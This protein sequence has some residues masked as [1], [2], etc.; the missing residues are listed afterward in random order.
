MDISGVTWRLMD[1][2]LLISR[3]TDSKPFFFFGG[4][5]KDMMGGERAG[6]PNFLG[7]QHRVGGVERESFKCT[8]QI[9]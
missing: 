4:W 8:E 9:E 1:I 3:G 5:G 2:L 6:R 7:A